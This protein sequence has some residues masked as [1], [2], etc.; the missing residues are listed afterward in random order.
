MKALGSAVCST[1]TWARGDQRQQQIDR[2]LGGSLLCK[3][4]IASPLAQLMGCLRVFKRA[5]HELLQFFLILHNGHAVDG[6][7]LSYDIAEIPRVRAK[8][9]CDAVGGRFEHVLATA[10]AE[11]AAYESDRGSAPPGA[12]FADGVDEQ[13]AGTIAMRRIAVS[14]CAVGIISRWVIG[15]DML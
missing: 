14:G 7:Q 6:E 11:G 15:C 4:Q 1:C 9:C 12:Q 3:Y 10:G 5:S 8:T 2:S 13:D